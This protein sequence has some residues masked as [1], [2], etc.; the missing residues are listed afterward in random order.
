[1]SLLENGLIKMWMDPAVTG[2]NK[3][4]G[5]SSHRIFPDAK[6]AADG[7]NPWEVDLDGVWDFYPAPDPVAAEAVITGGKPVSKWDS[8][9]VPGHPEMQGFGKPHYTN[10]RMPF[11][12]EPPR[13]PAD[14]PTAVF[15]RKI[16]IP[17]SWKGLR[18]VLHFGSAESFLAVWVNGRAVGVS[19]G[20]RTPAEFDITS[21]V[22]PG[23]AAEIRVATAK[24]SDATFMEDQDM[25][26][27]SGLPRSVRLVAMPP[28]HAED[29]FLRPQLDEGGRGTFEA[30]VL[31]G[32]DPVPEKPV[33][34]TI[35]LRD[36][37]GKPV[38]R[39]PLRA[40]AAWSDPAAWT[41]R[42]RGIA[43]FKAAVPKCKAWSH[44]T[45]SLYTA[46][47][48]V[49]YGKQTSVSRQRIGF[50]RVEVRDGQLLI[51]GKRVLIFGVNRHSYDPVHGRAVPR[52]RMRQDIAL[53]K[54]HH[55]NA[56][57]CSH[58]PPDPYWFELCDEHG[59]YVIDEADIETHAFY[60]S[61]CRDPR[62]AASWLDRVMRMVLRD[63]NHPSII[64]WSL[65]NES[66]YGPNHDAAAGWVRH[67]D[68]TRVLHYEGAIAEFPPGRTPLD[69]GL[70]TD[71]ICPMYASIQRLL[72]RER[73]LAAAAKAPRGRHEKLRPCDRPIILC[74][75]SHAMGNSNGSL[76]DYFHLFRTSSRVQG[77]FI[78]EW[79]DHGIPQ[80]DAGGCSYFAYGGDFGDVPNDANFVCD[81]MV[82]PDRL[83]HPAMLEHRY[84][85]QPVTVRGDGRGGLVMENRQSFTGLRW[86]RAEWTLF[87]EGAPLKMGK[88]TIPDCAPGKSAQ[89]PLPSKAPAGRTE[90]VLQ[91]R[92]IAK[93]AH[94]GFVPGEEVAREQVILRSPAVRTI[95]VRKARS[96]TLDQ[97]EKTA[98]VITG[99][100]RAV[101]NKRSGQLQSLHGPRGPL[102]FSG[103]E[104]A[105][106]RGA[107]D[108]D[109]LKLWS[110]Q[111][112]K[113]LGRWQAL[114]LDRVKPSD[115]KFSAVR[116]GGVAVLGI[117]ARL[118]GRSRPDDAAWKTTV[119]F[120]AEDSFLVEH[121]IAFG[122][123]DMT[124]LPRVGATW[125]TAQGLNRLRYYGRGPQEN[126]CDR[127]GGALLGV[128]ENDVKGEYFPYVMPQET[129]HHCDLRWLELRA[130][131]GHGLRFDFPVP[132][133][134]NA[135]HFTSADFFRAKHTTDLRPR[136]ET[137]LTIDAAHRGLGTASCGP[138][139]LPEYQ[140]TGRS[141]K[142]S[143]RVSLLS[144]D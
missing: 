98:T 55:F 82:H 117:T 23:A 139:A 31:I 64:A 22:A 129:G 30:E 113:P 93:S 32:A 81:G 20:S 87:V 111:D 7:T 75:Y 2:V 69:G 80:T 5:H 72:E 29:I 138:D 36:P 124:D 142:W 90:V 104:A 135:L 74:E 1:M 9:R 8:I 121:S 14:N 56:V 103:P 123:Q 40:E 51:N 52:E 133:E 60:H 97:N 11:D 128:Y 112:K 84:L 26:W 110:G 92:W 79:A 33:E 119:T 17:A 57:R 108:N 89:V 24:W 83:P 21:L 65:G 16:A 59:I 141:Y 28:V 67:Y 94:G 131:D 4:P 63:K 109:G 144:C 66:G 115:L 46:E 39:K 42:D 122:P 95:P 18:I 136:A 27:M 12:G 116:K 10:I 120:D 143:Y 134:A 91:I 130:D 78:W 47:I 58:Y 140:I 88:F 99:A 85:A 61:M 34:V 106:W 13:V 105:L 35:Q 25:W 76:S 37:Q 77:G 19:K 53:I 71:L 41:V 126:Y 48:T 125:V 50:R 73:E 86:L 15:R 100:I 96:I 54:K 118:S 62:Y 38:F 44:E 127:K 101:W 45:P 107:V 70:A 43:R 6:S 132:L 137:I 49:R 102:L 114:G 68:P 3:L